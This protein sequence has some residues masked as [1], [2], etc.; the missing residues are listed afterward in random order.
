VSADDAI[1]GMNITLNGTSTNLAGLAF[2]GNYSGRVDNLTLSKNSIIDL[3]NGTVSIMFD[4]FVMSTFTLDIYNWTGTTLWN[5]G[6]GNDTDKV[7]F[8]P[9]LS[10]A[11]LA[12]IR[13]H[14]GAVGVGDSFLGSGF[15][16]M[17]QTT[18]DGGLGYQ[19]IPVPE[20]E[21]WVSGA[22]LVIFGVF[23]GLRKRAIRRSVPQRDSPIVFVKNRRGGATNEPKSTH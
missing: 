21:T 22:L 5:G 9:D 17:P 2:S 16:L 18:F 14:S 6:T 11:A 3:G 12:K 23:I 8:G 1:N 7:Y 10:D 15:E 4:T 20:T 13:F 19:I